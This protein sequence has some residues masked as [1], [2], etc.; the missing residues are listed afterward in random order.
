M[1]KF[2]L[3]SAALAFVSLFVFAISQAG[4][5]TN[6]SQPN[7]APIREPVQ[8]VRFTIYDAG[9]YPREARVGKGLIAI[10][11][12]DLSGDTAGLVLEREAGQ[13]L[14]QIRRNGKHWRGRSEIKLTPGTYRVYDASRPS[15]RSTLIVEP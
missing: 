4:N 6:P 1:K 3:L 7:S 10:S 2:V 9:I 15:N 12:E 8:V 5:E 11:I 14:S 13:A